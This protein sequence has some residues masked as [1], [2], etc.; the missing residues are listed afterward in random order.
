MD[1]PIPL[2]VTPNVWQI[3]LAWT[4][5][6]VLSDGTHFT[7][8]D[9]GTR[10]DRDRLLGS[11]AAMNLNVG[12]CQSIVLTH[13][14]CDHAGNAAFIAEQSDA[15]CYAHA[16]EAPFLERRRTYVRR[17]L[18]A[19][20]PQGAMFAGGEVVF[21]VRRFK[22]NGLLRE[23]D[24][25]ETPAGTWRVHHTPGHTPG[26]ISFLRE[27]DNVLLSGDA[28][29]TIM[30]FSSQQG[31]SLPVALYNWDNSLVRQSARRIAALAP[32]I[33]LPGHGR[34]L[35]EQTAERIKDFTSTLGHDLKDSSIIIIP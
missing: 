21:P 30:P 11:L 18:R 31:L 28:L 20:T 2:E 10:W 25:V 22:L 29:L 7:L 19:L 8:V 6:Y 35:T 14:H 34:P 32:R 5:A 26:H 24:C 16:D 15:K 12:D 1:S 27:G 3:R 9:T 33:L 23:G 4:Q 13:G 17:G